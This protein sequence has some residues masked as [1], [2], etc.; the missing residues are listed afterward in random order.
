VCW[1]VGRMGKQEI[2]TEFWCEHLVEKV[3]LEVRGDSVLKIYI[4]MF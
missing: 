3:H 4:M 2:H 1:A